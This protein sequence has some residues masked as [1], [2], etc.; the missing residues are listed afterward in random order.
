MAKYL[1]WST[2]TQGVKTLFLARQ[3]H[4]FGTSFQ[5]SFL[6]SSTLPKH[7]SSSSTMPLRTSPGPHYLIQRFREKIP[8]WLFCSLIQLSYLLPEEDS[9]SAAKYIY[10]GNLFIYVLC[11]FVYV[12]YFSMKLGFSCNSVWLHILFG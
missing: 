9:H 4:R 6:L 3:S 7:S 12:L 2:H 10:C 1:V 8:I 5:F 11:I